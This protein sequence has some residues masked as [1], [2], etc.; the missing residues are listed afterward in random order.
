MSKKKKNT[1]TQGRWRL[2]PLDVV[3]ILVALA[4]AF[5]FLQLTAPSGGTPLSSNKSVT[6]RYTLELVSLPEGVAEL[7]HVG[8]ELVDKVEK[9]EIGK[10]TA[11]TVT[12]YG[13]SS[14]NTLTG[15]YIITEMPGR[16]T[17]TLTI[18]ARATDTGSSIEANGFAFRV[19][20]GVS[21]TGPGWSGI[22]Y[23]IGIE[24]D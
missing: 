18:E 6:L 1:K 14:K 22:G 10:V 17:A 7:I 24:R 19:G 21:V 23:I 4:A 16:E 20:G 5:A 11:V 3:I 15:E 8:D 9:H 2:N 12:P 13:I